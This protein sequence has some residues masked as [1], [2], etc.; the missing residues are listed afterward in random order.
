MMRLTLAVVLVT[1]AQGAEFFSGQAARAVLGQSSFSSRDAGLEPSAMTIQSGRLNV[2]D[3]SGR[4][5][6]FD[7]T[8]LPGVQAEV[9]PRG[10]DVCPLC[11]LAPAASIRQAVAPQSSTVSLSGNRLAAIDTRTHQILIWSDITAPRSSAGPDVRMNLADPGVL[12]VNEST[13]IDPVSVAVDGSRLFV[14]DAALHRVLVWKSLPTSANQPADAV[15]GQPDFSTREMNDSPRAGTIARPDALVSDGVNLF[16]GDSRDRRVLVFSTADAFLSSAFILNSGTLTPGSFAP[17]T[18]VTIMGQNLAKQDISAPDDKPVPLPT[19]L[20][21][22]EVYL[23]GLSL[24]L[25]SV[26]KTEIRAQLPYSIPAAGSGSLYVRSERADG[27]IAV[28]TPASVSFSSASPGIFG[29]EGHEPRPGILLHAYDEV[30]SGSPVTSDAPATSG[31]V[32]SVWVTGLHAVA[33]SSDQILPA[34][35]PSSGGELSFTPV[36]AFVNGQGAEVVSTTLPPS[37]I[38]VY[39]VQVLLPPNVSRDKS[40]LSISEDGYTSNVVTFPMRERAPQ[41]PE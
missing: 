30:E 15:L 12:A 14:G 6:I 32:V 7:L 40:E 34:G 16:V 1:A 19:K 29:F 33:T 5:S 21:G 20:G 37:S 13:L 17:G 18:L 28:T 2:A 26:G 8:K 22:V 25:L 27:S 11:G 38:G 36:H 24:P 3:R 9:M 31:E 10:T 4:V 23:D 39:Q 35:V 41:S